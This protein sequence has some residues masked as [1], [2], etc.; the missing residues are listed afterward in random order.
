LILLLFTASYPYDASAEQTFLE[1][2]LHHL[3]QVFERVILVPRKFVGNLLPLP[4]GLEVDESYASL[5][6]E[7][8]PL[9]ILKKTFLS[10]LLYNE[11]VSFPGL[12]LSPQAAKRLL[13]FLVGAQLTHDWVVEWFRRSAVN[14]KECIF[15][16]YWFDQG[17]YGIGLAKQT[18]SNL[19]LV[20]RVH[21][22]DLYEEFYYRPPY[23]PRRRAA[24]SLV[25]R[26]FPDSEAGLAYLND[27]Y[28]EFDPVYEPALLGVPDPGF[29]T[30]DSTD[31]VF[32]I[33]SCS[34]LEP[35][36]RIDL[37]IKGIAHAA[38]S[39]PDQ[40]FEWRHFGNGKRRA[41]L[42]ELAKCA[43]TSNASADLPGYSTKADLMRYYEQ[44]PVDV[45][46]N[47]SA[48][49]GTPVAVM[50][51]V[52]CGIPVIA[53]S[54][55]G[56]VEIASER[57]GLLLDADPTP[58]Q[59]GQALLSF[60]DDRDAR[61]SKRQGSRQIWQERYNADANFQA[62]AEKLRSIRES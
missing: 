17:A 15:Y 42:Q 23:W 32:R 31:D 59:I 55:G 24:L 48:T 18:C 13:A 41:E 47:V 33:V 53:T 50:E 35:V 11:I 39:R 26:L 10:P 21:G 4:G 7:I 12:L 16:T 6:D 45:F 29:T 36:K 40:H 22:Y 2:E 19:K 54:V 56:N 62:F 51:A 34:I 8:D 52:S 46:M 28:P 20:S 61:L 38:K 27:R 57:N 30:P 9:T 58:E 43:F 5:L 1:I 60:W 49:E 3:Q 44:N 14:P 25:D 37:L